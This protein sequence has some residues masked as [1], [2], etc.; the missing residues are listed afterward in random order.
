MLEKLKSNLLVSAG[1]AVAGAPVGGRDA[2]AAVM[3]DTDDAGVVRDTGETGDSGRA[4][5]DEGL[6][7]DPALELLTEADD[8]VVDEEMAAIDGPKFMSGRDGTGG[9]PAAAVTATLPG[10]GTG[11]L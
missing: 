9:A 3:G 4:A 7:E 5:D 10:R 8:G 1:E 2:E 11:G 6:L